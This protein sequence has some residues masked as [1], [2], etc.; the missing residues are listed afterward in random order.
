MSPQD[1]IGA[2]VTKNGGPM[3]PQDGIAYSLTTPIERPHKHIQGETLFGDAPEAPAASKPKTPKPKPGYTD[4]FTALWK[5]WPAGVRAKSEKE[6]AAKRFAERRK[7]YDVETIMLAA[8]HYLTGVNLT[9]SDPGPWKPPCCQVQVFLNG[10]FEAAVEAAL[11]NAA[12]RDPAKR[13]DGD[14]VC[15]NGQWCWPDGTPVNSA[16]SR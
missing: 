2:D 1:G 13:R 9:G 16:L 3:S 4:E 7:A 15:I 12:K 10:K 11:E 8:E 5:R 14:Q 6:T